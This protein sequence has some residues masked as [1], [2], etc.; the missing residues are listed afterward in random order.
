[1]KVSLGGY[2]FFNT[3]LEGKMDVFGYLESMK[4]RYHLNAADLWNGQFC[5]WKDNMW[6]M[7]EESVLAKIREALDERELELVNIAVDSAHVWDE[8]ADK[9]EC[10]RENALKHLR[11]GAILGARTVRI[12]TGGYNLRAFTDEQFE[13]V[14]ERFR[15][16][17]D[18]ADDYGFMIGPENH[19][20]PSLVPAE[21]KR[22]AEAVDRPNFGILLHVGR[23]KED[24]ETGDE[25]VAPY[26]YHTHMDPSSVTGPG[27]LDK[28]DML[29]QA[30]YNGYWG[31]EHNAKSNQ[32]GE[33]EWLLSSVKRLVWESEQNS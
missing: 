33:V 8:D 28:I 29:K 11:A 12:D 13:F 32:Y 3:F 27:A 22:L 19:M 26:V 10:L 17:C 9:R 4:Y 30:G 23:W 16:Y 25:L 31:A 5:T 20:G 21:M 1:M 24:K 15:E 18:I 2:S 7:P 14:V 6:V